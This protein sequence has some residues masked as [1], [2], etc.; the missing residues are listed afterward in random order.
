[1]TSSAPDGGARLRY[2]GDEVLV[3]RRTWQ[4]SL[5]RAACRVRRKVCLGASSRYELFLTCK[6][7][8]RDLLILFGGA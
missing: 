6:I 2:I 4:P 5:L 3:S 7:S 8:G 1:M